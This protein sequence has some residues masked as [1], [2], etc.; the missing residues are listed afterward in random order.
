MPPFSKNDTKIIKESQQTLSTLAPKENSQKSTTFE[1]TRDEALANEVKSLSGYEEYNT[2]KEAILKDMRSYCHVYGE[3]CKVN[4]SLIDSKPSLDIQLLEEIRCFR[5][6][7]ADLYDV[8]FEDEK[9]NDFEFVDLKNNL[10][11]IT[12]FKEFEKN[13]E[14]FN[15]SNKKNGVTDIENSSYCD[16]FGLLEDYL[17]GISKLRNCRARDISFSAQHEKTKKVLSSKLGPD[18]MDAL[19]S[20]RSKCHLYDLLMIIGPDNI[21]F[22][23]PTLEE[24]QSRSIKAIINIIDNLEFVKYLPDLNQAKKDLQSEKLTAELTSS[25]KSLNLTISKSEEVVQETFSP[26]V[27]TQEHTNKHSIADSGLTNANRPTSKNVK[28]ESGRTAG[29]SKEE[30]SKTTRLDRNDTSNKQEDILNNKFDVNFEGSGNYTYTTPGSNETEGVSFDDSYLP[31]THPKDETTEGH[32]Y[33][34]FMFH[35]DVGYH[36]EV[37]NDT[38]RLG[39]SNELTSSSHSNKGLIIGV[40]LFFGAI[41]LGIAGWIVY[42]FKFPKNSHKM[43]NRRDGWTEIPLN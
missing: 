9:E 33:D 22:Q 26:S 34:G 12:N 11:R 6:Y 40:S 18:D 41:F 29:R 8:K 2:R 3:K 31:T 16:L 5:P 14:V 30:T 4:P 13:L 24:F 42:K 10:S 43:K 38:P 20:L 7:I 15:V 37:I 39:T 35:N 36:H 23:S 25:F 17:A 19:L 28:E 32:F 27:G 1:S 21:K